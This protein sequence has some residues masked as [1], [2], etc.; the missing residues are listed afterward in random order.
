MKR[1]WYYGRYSRPREGPEAVAVPQEQPAMSQ[2]W[3]RGGLDDGAK[4]WR[5]YA[6]RL[7]ERW[8]EEKGEAVR[9]I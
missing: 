4:A 8:K 5:E 7:W 1:Y 9:T 3:M 6:V 2:A